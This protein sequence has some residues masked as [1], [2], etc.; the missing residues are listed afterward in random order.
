MMH[1]APSY[2]PSFRCI[3]DRCQHNCCIGWE[4]GIDDRTA[5]KYKTIGGTLGSRL[6][7]HI[8][9]TDEGCS[10]AL[11]DDERCPFLNADG[12]CDIFCTLGEDALC[13]I[14]ADHPRFRNYFSDRTEI[15]LGLCCEEAARV[16]LTS[17]NDALIRLADNGEQAELYPE[18]AALLAAREDLF[19]IAR[20][21]TQTIRERE[22]ALLSRAGCSP[23]SAQEL[24]VRFEPLERLEDDWSD[25][26]R[27][28]SDA[29]DAEPPTELQTAFERLF[30]Y[31]LYRHIPGALDDERLSQRI[32]FAAHSVKVLR[33][34]CAAHGNTADVLT[35]LAR[36]YSA[37]IEYSD[38]NLDTLLESF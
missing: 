21:R 25:V 3:A 18:E 19:T 7:A 33:L 2:Y 11:T 34:L 22:A 23:L 28:L 15:G 5:A 35:D 12:L 20:D 29:P 31:F 30:V 9:T 37:E 17:D 24:F 6:A 16:I 8:V 14:C 38:E 13:Q 27:G 1:V 36:R 26:L 10:F 32:A 4:I